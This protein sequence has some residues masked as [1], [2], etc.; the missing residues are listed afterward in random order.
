[1]QSI[2]FNIHKNVSIRQVI[3]MEEPISILVFFTFELLCL[4][5]EMALLYVSYSS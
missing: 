1:M 3:S 2:S 4:L 5:S